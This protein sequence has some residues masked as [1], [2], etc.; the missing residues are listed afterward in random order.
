MK[1]LYLLIAFT[2]GLVYFSNAQ[3]QQVTLGTSDDYSV[4]AVPGYTYTW[5]VDI[6]GT[7][8]DVSGVTGN[9][10]NILWDKAEG[11]YNITV[12]ATETATSCISETE[13]ITVE[14]LGQSSVLFAAA[15]AAQTCSDL[16][17]NIFGGG[18]S[19]G[20]SSF[21]VQ[22]TGGLAPY[23]LKYKVLDPLDAQVGAEVTVAGLSATDIIDVPNQFINGGSGNT[24]YKIV[25]V[26]ATTKDGASVDIA[27]AIADNTRT[28]TVLPKPKLTGGITF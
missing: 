28:I 15:D 26:S 25:I 20:N 12:F 1:K 14:V 9:S 2:L 6:A 19:G 21:E 8:I 10:I 24:I 7:S 23:E 18:E 17:E 3:D 5:T 22:F 27:A 11:T 16:D 4:T 13:T